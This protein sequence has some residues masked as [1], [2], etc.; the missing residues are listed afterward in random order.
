MAQRE[1]KLDKVEHVDIDKVK[2]YWRNPRRVT[3][4]VVNQLVESIRSYGFQQ[5]IVVDSDYV[6]IVGHTRYAA[7]RRME[8]TT[9]PV[10]VATKLSDAEVKQ[11]RLI[12]NRSGEFSSWDYEKLMDEIVEI[13]DAVASTFFPEIASVEA[14]TTVEEQETA[15]L[16]QTW[17]QVDVDVD[18]VC[19]SCFHGFN[20]EVTKADVMAG[21][22][23]APRDDEQEQAH[24]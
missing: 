16:E 12:D 18:F 20:V 21:I 13:E 24:G 5:P 3:E 22:I 1:M 10:V 6:I 4:D 8:A 11:Y 19:P 7:L 17:E 14:A 15:Y 23:R 2:P 9:V